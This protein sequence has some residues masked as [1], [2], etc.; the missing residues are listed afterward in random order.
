MDVSLYGR[1]S[2]W[3]YC[4]VWEAR[5][6]KCR[7]KATVDRQ[8]GLLKRFVKPYIGHVPVMYLDEGMIMRVL[9]NARKEA[10]DSVEAGL[11]TAL[12]SVIDYA[13][14]DGLI[15]RESVSDI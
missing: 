3:S 14:G 5:R 7:A 6:R 12:R 11:R 4:L 2:V 15:D 9:R 13:K 8:M 10:G 1:M